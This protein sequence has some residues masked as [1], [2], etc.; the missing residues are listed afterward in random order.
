M[1]LFIMLKHSSCRLELKRLSAAPTKK[2]WRTRAPA[3]RD[4]RYRLP[5]AAARCDIPAAAAEVADRLTTTADCNKLHVRLDPWTTFHIS[6]EL[7]KGALEDPRGI[8]GSFFLH[9]IKTRGCPF[10]P[11]TVCCM[12]P[13]LCVIREKNQ[14]YWRNICWVFLY[15]QQRKFASH[16]FHF[17]RWHHFFP[18]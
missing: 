5:A 12:K 11:F 9:L 6:A 15:Q 8:Y 2:R 4:K 14:A 13:F 17:Y 16:F 7:R 1:F 18:S 3:R 10:V